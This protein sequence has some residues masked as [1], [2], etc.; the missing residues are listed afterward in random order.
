M[1]LATRLMSTSGRAV[2][3][4]TAD[5]LHGR[6]LRDEPTRCR[7]ASPGSGSTE[8]TQKPTSPPTLPPVQ[9]LLIIP[10]APLWRM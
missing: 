7:Q 2:C 5:H 3:F 6:S 8:D 1:P 4:P 10:G 9:S